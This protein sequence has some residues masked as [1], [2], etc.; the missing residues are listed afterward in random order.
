MQYET[1]YG[2][3]IRGVR[4]ERKATRSGSLFL[5]FAGGMQTF[6]NAVEAAIQP[7]P[8]IVHGEALALE[9]H[10]ASWRVRVGA[11]WPRRLRRARMSAYASGHILRNIAPELANELPQFRIHR[12]SW[13]TLNLRAPNS[14]TLSTASDSLRRNQSGARSRQSP[15]SIQNFLPASASGL[16]ALRAFIVGREDKS[17]YAPG[18]ETPRISYGRI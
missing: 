10:D 18:R 17:C 3:L 2:S 14:P 9:R 11:D 13:L 16:A 7:T 5:S 8:E 6:S 1:E 15:R 12:R 4:K